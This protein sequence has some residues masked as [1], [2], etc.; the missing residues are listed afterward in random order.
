MIVVAESPRLLLVTQQDHACFAADL[1][2]LWRRDG[3]PEHPRRE[4]LLFATRH[5]DNGW[6]EID[7]VPPVDPKTGRPYDFLSLPRRFRFELWERGVRRFATERPAAALLIACHALEL[8]RSRAGDPAWRE[9]LA[10]LEATLQELRE[11]I[12]GGAAELAADY[13]WLRLADDLSLRLCTRSSEAAAGDGYHARLARDGPSPAPD[14][15]RRRTIPR[16]SFS[17]R[18]AE[19]READAP[20]WRESRDGPAGRPE[21]LEIDPFPLAGATRFQ[22]PCRRIPDRHYRGDADLAGELGAARWESLEVR[23]APWGTWT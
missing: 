12:G 18:A 6:R 11:A 4:V 13:R 5:H 20:R 21:T 7:A 22:I 14:T 3:L 10:G 8:H 17:G 19:G 15:R 2:A 1:L 16:A 23:V 9:F